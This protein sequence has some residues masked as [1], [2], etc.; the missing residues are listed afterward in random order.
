MPVPLEYVLPRNPSLSAGRC[1]FDSSSAQPTET[2]VEGGTSQRKRGTSVN[3][4][5]SGFRHEAKIRVPDKEIWSTLRQSQVRLTV[6]ARFFEC[7]PRFVLGGISSFN[8]S[9]GKLVKA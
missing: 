9:V 2:N 5:N 8:K 3:L 4:C 7:C 6:H 1:R